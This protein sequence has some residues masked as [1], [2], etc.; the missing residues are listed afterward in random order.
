MFVESDTRVCPVLGFP[1]G[2]P[3]MVYLW[4]MV[5]RWIRSI[6]HV[7]SVN[8]MS[9]LFPTL[10]S[11]W[12]FPGEP[13]C[14][15]WCLCSGRRGSRQPITSSQTWRI[16]E[17]HW[18]TPG[19][20]L[21]PEQFLVAYQMWQKWCRKFSFDDYL[22]CADSEEGFYPMYSLSFDTIMFQFQ[23]QM[24]VR[25][26]DKGFGDIRSTQCICSPWSS[27]LARSLTVLRTFVSHDLFPLKP[28]LCNKS[29]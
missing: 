13:T 16:A 29:K 4:K 27:D 19:I 11:C 9:H 26:L 3:W 28:S 23:L 25:V 15:I 7:S 20:T 24:E 6:L 12:R 2:C 22:L 18:Y 17:N 8:S 14:R 21:F 5:F 10:A 1:S